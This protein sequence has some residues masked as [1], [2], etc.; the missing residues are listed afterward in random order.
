MLNEEDL[1]ELGSPEFAALFA[2]DPELNRLEL[3]RYDESEE[4]LLLS[5]AMHFEFQIGRVPVHPLTAATWSFLWMLGNAYA[6][7][8]RVSETDKDVFLYL[9]SHDPRRL[10]CRI[11]EIPG[12]ASGF[13]KA[14]GLAP[15][16]LHQGIIRMIRTAFRPLGML[17]LTETEGG[18]YD[19]VWLAGIAALAARESNCTLE[20]CKFTMSLGEVCALYVDCYRR[21]TPDKC[22]GYHG[23]EEIDRKILQRT[24]E[25]QQQ[26]LNRK[27]Q[28]EN[29]A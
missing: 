2:D 11:H 16:D 21:N 14:S 29:N 3:L 15:G 4:L 1:R 18:R 23:N 6:R 13:G 19:T 12:A 8:T 25:L 5:G 10:P 17:P 26:F 28:G 7:N 24:R 27:K 22:I 20:Y 9:L